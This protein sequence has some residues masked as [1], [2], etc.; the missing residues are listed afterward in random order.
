[1]AKLV[2]P[3]LSVSAHGSIAK[4]ITYS[5]RASCNQ[6]RFQKANK[7]ANTSLQQTQRDFFLEALDSWKSLTNDEKAEWNDFNAS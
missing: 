2:G 1:M 7:D 5:K 4:R 6:V 3:L